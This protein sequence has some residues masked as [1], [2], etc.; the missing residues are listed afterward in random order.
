MKLCSQRHIQNKSNIYNGAFF[1]FVKSYFKNV[2][3]SIELPLS[4]IFYTTHP[5]VKKLNNS[6]NF[7]R[8][9]VL[10]T[11]EHF[12]SRNS[13]LHNGM[14]P[15][16]N[17]SSHRRCSTR[18]GVLRNFANFTGKHP[19]QSLFFNKVVGLGP[20]TLLKKRLQHRYFPVNFAKFL[21]TPFLI[22][23]LQ[24]TASE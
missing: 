16:V 8:K 24:A 20:A 17:K 13:K 2:L 22:E 14:V 3:N 4:S 10:L 19:Y 21:R 6:E 5:F 15:S 1:T 7:G 11:M 12:F 18:K 23:H 9:S